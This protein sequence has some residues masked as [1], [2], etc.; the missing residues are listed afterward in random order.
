MIHYI[1]GRTGSGKSRFVHDNI[2]SEMG[3]KKQLLIVPEQYTLQAEIELIEDLNSFGIIDVEVMSFNRLCF[4]IIEETGPLNV[5]E[6]NNMGKAMVLRSI[7]DQKSEELQVYSQISQKQGFVDK[8]SSLIG[9]MKRVG[10]DEIILSQNFIGDQLVHRK[11]SDLHKILSYYNAFM[12]KGYFDEEDRLRLILDRINKSTLL[13]DAVVYLDGFDSYSQSEYQLIEEMLKIVEKLY[14]SLT[15]IPTETSD[16]FKPVEN[17]Y[18]KLEAIRDNLQL[19]KTEI[20]LKKD[21][22]NNELQWL[23]RSFFEYP[24]APY[25]KEPNAVEMHVVNNYYDEIAL[26]SEKILDLIRNENF[27]YSDIGIVTGGIEIYSPVIKR[28]FSEYQIPY[29]IDDKISVIT[30]PLIQYILSL[31]SAVH[32]GF[33]YED[34][35]KIVKTQLTDL[36]EVAGFELENHAIQYGLR[37]K[38]W[39]EPLIDERLNEE[40]VKL[41]EPL[42]AFQE[43]IKHAKTVKAYVAVLF[44]H[45][46]EMK[47]PEKLEQWIEALTRD[48]L[49]DKAQETAQIWNKIIEILDQLVELE[50]EDKKDIKGFLRILEAGF[51]ELQLGLIPPTLDQVVIGSIERSKTKKVK[52]LFVIGL[53]DGVMPKKYADEGLLL[54]DEKK[55][56]KTLGLDLETD[57]SAIT[58]RDRFSTYVAFSKATSY[59][60]VTYALSDLEG[61]ALRPSIY[62][63]R[64]KKLYPKLQVKGHLKDL[65]HPKKAYHPMNHLKKLTE[66]LRYYKDDQ[67]IDEDWF[68][69]LSYYYHHDAL[70]EQ[71]E[72]LET[73]FDYDNQVSAIPKNKAEVLF[74]LPLKASV[75][76]LERYRRCPFSH[77]VH[78]GLRPKERKSYELKMPDIGSLLH[79]TLEEFDG[80]MKNRNLEWHKI[81][82]SN[83]FEIIDEIVDRLVMD[84][85]YKIFESSYRYSYM[86]QKLKRVSKRAAWTLV[87]QVRAGQ[88]KPYAHEIIFSSNRVQFSVPPI[89]IELNNHERLL[90]EGRI[91]RI[92]LYEENHKWYVKVID[93]KSG[94]QKF[95]LSEVYQGLQLQLIVY[96]NAILE[97]SEYFRQDVLYPA[98]V[99]YFKIDDPMVEMELNRNTLSDEEILKLL[100][101]DGLLLENIK[102][103]KAMDENILESKKSDIIPV[104]LKKDDS[105]SSRSKTADYESFLGLM[106]HVKLIIANLGVEIHEG[107]TEIKPIK[108]SAK[109]ACQYCQ[110]SS[111]CQFETAF[112]NNYENIDSLKDEDVL[113]L[114]RK[115]N[116]NGSVDE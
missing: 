115:E 114:V 34:V 94:S 25:P 17:T 19:P 113:N 7:L 57:G 9:E 38:K 92:D 112:G 103:I 78:Y 89:V 99:F 70:K 37:G 111:I 36:E 108:Q 86:I 101:M 64:F 88:F 97:N 91:D 60:H 21:H 10:A 98:G 104:E 24:F 12:E 13:K 110:Y 32:S 30:H 39:L 44:Q 3:V 8:L 63:D 81:E 23:E 80:E 53:N 51:S 56:L 79:Q 62:V 55:Y 50:G 95:S 116:K 102:I 84:Y 6:I 5:V 49:M 42:F 27:R 76:R 35:F 74:N 72:R 106:D 29:F 87:L 93:Y 82:K 109:T 11:L 61:K 58:S 68:K 45:L 4:K 90:L 41:I 48:H 105:L 100:K 75:S 46:I 107:K 65:S 40:K 14:V 43:A 26:V 28:V 69:V 18:K 73:A 67:P 54:D 31:L 33:K 85:G 1:L 47:I 77:F 20:L 52:A 66:Q 16:L 22:A 83:L 96:L 15:Y 2:K 59:L 71:I